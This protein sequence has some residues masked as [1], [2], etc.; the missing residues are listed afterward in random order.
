MTKTFTIRAAS[1]KYLDEGI[2]AKLPTNVRALVHASKF[3]DSMDPSPEKSLVGGAYGSNAGKLY[4]AQA[5][6][7]PLHRQALKKGDLNSANRIAKK[8]RLTS[9]QTEANIMALS[10]EELLSLD[11]DAA[12]KPNVSPKFLEEE[13]NVETSQGEVALSR[14]SENRLILL[15]EG[16]DRFSAFKA[17]CQALLEDILTS[18]ST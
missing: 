5:I 15:E 17:Y 3:L 4:R 6:A 2:T 9:E 13:L 11:T 18:D 12:Q 16:A 14:L 10:E 8:F 1:V 7:I